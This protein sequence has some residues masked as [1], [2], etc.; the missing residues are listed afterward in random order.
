M[1]PLLATQ[2]SEK[3]IDMRQMVGSHILYENARYLVISQSS[4]KPSKEKY[5]LHHEGER[6]GKPSR[7]C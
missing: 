5:E 3:V 2:S 1:D 6:S 7:I 4:V